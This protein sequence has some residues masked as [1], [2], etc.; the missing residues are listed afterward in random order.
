MIAITANYHHPFQSIRNTR[1]FISASII[2]STAAA[3]YFHRRGNDRRGNDH[4]GNDCPSRRFEALG[5]NVFL[6]S[7]SYSPE[8]HRYREKT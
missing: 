8:H 6:A 5:E 4:G 2:T 1:N 7:E 3:S